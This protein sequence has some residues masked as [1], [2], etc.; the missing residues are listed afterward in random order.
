MKLISAIISWLLNK[1]I[2]ILC[3]VAILTV[4]FSVRDNFESQVLTFWNE[5]SGKNSQELVDNLNKEIDQLKNVEI[6]NLQKELDNA[7]KNIDLQLKSECESN[8]PWYEFYRVDKQ[9]NKEVACKTL[10]TQYKGNVSIT[11]GKIGGCQ[12]RQNLV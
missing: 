7:R 4:L 11:T 8:H 12:K 6:P 1:I 2:G 10:E 9:F 3:L 5:V